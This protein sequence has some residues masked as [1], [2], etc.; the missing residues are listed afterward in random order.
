M[1]INYEWSKYNTAVLDGRFHCFSF[2]KSLHIL[3]TFTWLP[4]WLCDYSYLCMYIYIAVSC[5]FLSE[6]NFLIRI[7]NFPL[8]LWELYHWCRYSEEPIS[9]IILKEI[10]QSI[11]WYD[12]DIF[13]L[14]GIFP[15]P[16][17]KFVSFYHSS[18]QPVGHLS[19]PSSCLRDSIAWVYRSL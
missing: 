10:A 6:V 4:E 18:S 17:F 2:H 13:C 16:K 11:L 15:L 9:H 7:I 8:I 1:V 12:W 5:F 14:E 19:V 3:W